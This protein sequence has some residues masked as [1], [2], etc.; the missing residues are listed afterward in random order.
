[1]L[2]FRTL[3]KLNCVS[4]ASL[5]Q[6]VVESTI[7]ETIMVWIDPLKL[8]LLLKSET[9]TTCS[10]PESL[11]I[12]LLIRM[13]LTS[14]KLHQLLNISLVEVL[15]QRLARKSI[16]MSQ[17]PLFTNSVI[18]TSVLRDLLVNRHCY[19]KPRKVLGDVIVL[20]VRPQVVV[21]MVLVTTL[22]FLTLISQPQKVFV[23]LLT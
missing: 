15:L 19:S 1:M 9:M 21:L 5:T 10:I 17:L 4:L 22:M 2:N 23:L 3:K 16:M 14:R 6:A 20:V 12:P 18:W 11:Q 8:L 7:T 13:L